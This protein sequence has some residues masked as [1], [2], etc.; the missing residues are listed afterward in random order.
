MKLVVDEEKLYVLLKDFHQLTGLKVSFSKDYDTPILGVPHN[1]CALCRYKQNDREFYLR[2]KASDKKAYD[3][4]SRSDEAYIYE[5]HYH[6]TEALQPVVVYGKHVGYFQIGQM[7]TDRDK[8]IRLNRPHRLRALP[9]R[10][11]T[12]ERCVERAQQNLDAAR[13]RIHRRT[14][15]GTHHRRRPV[16][17]L[18]LQP[19]PPCS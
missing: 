1:I 16:P 12:V 11:P 2:C 19:P 17:H 14:L 3:I 7:L 13:S 15:P 4:A 18:S 6:L 10:R 9:A 5:C 8:F